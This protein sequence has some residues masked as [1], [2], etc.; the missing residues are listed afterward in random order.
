MRTNVKLINIL[1]PGWPLP[2]FPLSRKVL[3]GGFLD[4]TN[5]RA[6]SPDGRRC[7]AKRVVKRITVRGSETPATPPAQQQPSTP[8]SQVGLKIMKKM[9]TWNDI[10]FQR[11]QSTRPTSSQ[12]TVLENLRN[13]FSF[14]IFQVVDFSGLHHSKRYSTSTG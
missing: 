14:L 2:S 12:G 8:S 10:Q 3:W 11:A 13:T 4:L 6:K 1:I 9:E 5:L 7:R